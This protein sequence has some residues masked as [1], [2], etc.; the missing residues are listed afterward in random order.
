MTTITAPVGRR[1]SLAQQV[2]INRAGDVSSVQMLL[3]HHAQSSGLAHPLPVTGVCDEATL[4]GIETFQRQAVGLRHPDGRVDPGGRTLAALDLPPA[5][6]AEQGNRRGVPPASAL[7]RGLV[8]APAYNSPT[9]RADATGAFH[10][11]ARQFQ[12]IH[13]LPDPVLFD[14]RQSAPACRR[15]VLDAIQAASGPLDVIAY[16]GHG[17]VNALSSAGFRSQDI[18]ELAEA[19][20]AKCRDGAPIVLYACSAGAFGGFAEGLANAINVGPLRDEYCRVVYGHT[21]SGHSFYNPYV[22]HFP[23]RAHVVQPGSL[24]FPR[25]RN[26]LRTTNLWARFPFL[27]DAQIHAEIGVPTAD[28]G[29]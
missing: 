26:A 12:R 7:R 21:C 22:T 10:P 14:N 13:G 16:F 6:L 27:G 28:D 24:D 20:R 23:A 1:G 25:W 5:V 2:E 15:A 17:L 19:I 4:R 8:L 29:H 3:N 9:R 11:G 18:G